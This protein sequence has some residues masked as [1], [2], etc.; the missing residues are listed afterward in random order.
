MD[1]PF[2]WALYHGGS[3]LATTSSST[4]SQASTLQRFQSLLWWQDHE[5]GLKEQQVAPCCSIHGDE[6]ELII[7]RDL[8]VPQA[9]KEGTRTLIRAQINGAATDYINRHS[10]R[11][12][13]TMRP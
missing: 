9:P 5:L 4:F 11:V 13:A 2:V 6:P 10:K 8:V 12:L 1:L 7:T 3:S